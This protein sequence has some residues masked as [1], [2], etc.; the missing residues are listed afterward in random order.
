M[1]GSSSTTST[2]GWLPVG[3]TAALVSLMSLPSPSVSAPGSVTVPAVSPLTQRTCR[4]TPASS[5]RGPPG[6]HGRK[7]R[8][9]ARC[10]VP[11]GSRGSGRRG[12]RRSAQ[13]VTRMAKRRVVVAGAYDRL[14]DDRAEDGARQRS[15]GDAS[16]SRHAHTGRQR[17]GVGMGGAA[18]DGA[19]RVVEQVTEDPGGLLRRRSRGS[20]AAAGARR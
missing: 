2:L 6:A 1:S 11:H 14:R 18:G 7:S 9:G 19:A 13:S 10:P 4:V 8:A 12:P 16:R 3:S 20:R 5:G 17:A 15:T